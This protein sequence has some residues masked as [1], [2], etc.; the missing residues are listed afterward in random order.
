MSGPSLGAEDWLRILRRLAEEFQLAAPVKIIVIGGAA[1]ALAYGARRT[2]R[3]VDAV[4]DCATSREVLR[5]ADRIREEFGL[6]SGWLN[7][8]ARHAGF[9]VEP[10]LEG[11]TVLA[12]PTTIV[13]APSLEHLTAMKL[14]A[15]RDDTD[16]DDAFMLLRRFQAAGHDAEGTWS[17]I[18]GLVSAG[19]RSKARYNL[20]KIWDLLDESD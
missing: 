10:I 14:S 13:V 8:N 19:A 17:A 16:I 1:M 12:T 7:E 20:L 9:L 11:P 2:T 6:D 5:A 4:L 18:G 3:D 15:I